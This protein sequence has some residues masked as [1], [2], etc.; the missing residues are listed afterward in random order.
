MK[1]WL[2]GSYLGILLILLYAPIFIVIVFSFTE[3]KVLGNWTGFSLKLYQ[4]LFTGG[5]HH[6]LSSA[7]WNT[8]LIGIIAATFSTIL[9]QWQQ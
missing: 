9:A 7:L 5:I 6:T 8:F 3:A 4:S 1:K 2:T